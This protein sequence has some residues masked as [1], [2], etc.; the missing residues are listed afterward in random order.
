MLSESDIRFSMIDPLMKAIHRCTEAIATEFS[1][2]NSDKSIGSTAGKA[3][4]LEATPT[5]QSGTSRNSVPDYTLYSMSVP[6]K[7]HSHNA[8]IQVH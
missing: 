2:S 6:L 5:Y 1:V 7:V 3:P 8:M 4:S